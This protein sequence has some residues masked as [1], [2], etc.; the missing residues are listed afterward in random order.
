MTDEEILATLGFF[1]VERGRNGRRLREA[2]MRDLPPSIR[3]AAGD[4]LVQLMRETHRPH[5]LYRVKED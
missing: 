1:I 4:R 5:Q 2:E 3:E